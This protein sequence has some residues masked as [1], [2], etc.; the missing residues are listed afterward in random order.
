MAT[1]EIITRVILN[2]LDED[3]LKAVNADGVTLQELN[4]RAQ[5]FSKHSYQRTRYHVRLLEKFGLIYTAFKEGQVV[6]FPADS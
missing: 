3:I 4:R 5:R 2:E 1:A 6:C